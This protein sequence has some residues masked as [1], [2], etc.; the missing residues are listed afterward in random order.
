MSSLF[1]CSDE[2]FEEV[3]VS[4]AYELYYIMS[5]FYKD[6]GVLLDMNEKEN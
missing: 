4:K 5:L 3:K 2:V 1:F 6:K